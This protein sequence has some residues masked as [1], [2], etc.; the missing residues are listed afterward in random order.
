V[1]VVIQYSATTGCHDGTCIIRSDSTISNVNLSGSTLHFQADGP[2]GS[3][4]HA[5]VTIPI[6]SVP[7]KDNLKVFVDNSQLPS[8]SITIVSD[9]SNYYVSFSFTFHSPAQI[10]IQL[11]GP[12]NAATPTILGLNPTLFYAVIGALV[13]VVIVL[14]A[15][16]IVKR[17]PDKVS[18]PQ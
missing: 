10:D 9:S 12:E 17:R 15:V 7:N 6:S 4:G 11:T 1:A 8:S 2:S 18:N 16:I 5:N 13:A 14:I 3:T